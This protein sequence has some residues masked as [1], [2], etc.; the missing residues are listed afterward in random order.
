MQISRCDHPIGATL[1]RSLRNDVQV[2]VASP[3][4]YE[5]RLLPE[6]ERLI[7]RC[8]D[9]R[10]REFRAG[11]ACAKEALRR[12]GS[13]PAPL[14]RNDDRTPIW[15]TGYVGSITHCPTFCAAIAGRADILRAVGLDAEPL[16]ELSDGVKR[17]VCS[18]D[19][20][21]A[22]RS[23][24]VPPFLIPT[25]VFSAKEAFY[26]CIYTVEKVFLDFRDVHLHFTALSEHRGTFRVTPTGPRPTLAAEVEGVWMF[27]DGLVIC[28]ALL[29]PTD[30]DLHTPSL[31]GVLGEKS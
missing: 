31:E 11:R 23:L 19:E 13:S 5:T 17:I 14:L 8:V 4:C 26:K 9:K 29:R 30:A 20:A 24:P 16:V 10:Q 2:C 12:A 25:L 18:V 21:A 3:K 28:A 1:S 22:L 7:E 15:P 6:E 27:A